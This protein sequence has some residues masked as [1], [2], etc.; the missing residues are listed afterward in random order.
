MGEPGPIGPTGLKGT[1]GQPGPKGEKGHYGIIGLVG[2]PG[3]PGEKGQRGPLG[4]T[5]TQGKKGDSGPSG[6]SGLPGPQGDHGRPG[7]AGPPGAKGVMGPTGPKGQPGPAG[8]PGPPGPQ[9]DPMPMLQPTPEK[10]G[11]RK[12]RN[13]DSHYLDYNADFDPEYMGLD[14]NGI[15]YNPS[16][17]ELGEIFA[18]L[19]SLKQELQMMKEPMGTIENPARSCRDLWLCHPEYT[20][21]TYHID[22][23]GG[24]AKDAV[25]VTC[26][27]RE[28]GVTCIKPLQDH[29]KQNRWSK[30]TPGA[31]FSE[32][33]RGFKINYNVT[34]PQFKFLRLLSSRATQ[35]FT[36]ECTSSV[37]WFDEA[38]GSYDKSIQLMGYDDVILGH[39]ATENRFDVV[40]DTCTTGDKNG[41]V[42]IQF[43]TRDV[44]ILPIKDWR[45]YDFGAKHQKHGFELSE[46]CFHG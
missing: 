6:N 37:G 8:P 29:A 19:E 31:W 40:E 15:D 9:G 36:Y 42:T 17:S 46:V 18:A 26:K 22:P 41:R 2:E 12:R 32:Y 21:G 11:N 10:S 45:A 5:G 14:V 28:K 44:D 34:D 35:E 1:K 20:D 43:N 7:V 24:C 25:E 33:N 30:E 23:N 39:S 38:T 16:G 27:M 4:Q 13:L 3:V